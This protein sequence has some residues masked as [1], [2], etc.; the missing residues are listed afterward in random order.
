MTSNNSN[1]IRTYW[2]LRLWMNSRVLYLHESAPC[3]SFT[4][5]ST[6]WVVGMAKFTTGSVPSSLRFNVDRRPSSLANCWRHSSTVVSF[7]T[8]SLFSAT[9]TSFFCGFVVMNTTP[10]LHCLV[11]GLR[12]RRS[13]CR[14]CGCGCCCCCCWCCC[15]CSCDP[16]SPGNPP[17]P[18][19]L[20]SFV[21]NNDV[22]IG[23][24]TE[25]VEE[26]VI[27][28]SPSGI[29]V[30]MD[31]DVV[32][33]AGAVAAGFGVCWCGGGDGDGGVSSTI[34]QS[35][36]LCVCVCVF[37]CVCVCVWN[38]AWSCPSWTLQYHIWGIH[39]LWSTSRSHFLL[40]HGEKGGGRLF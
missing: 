35:V 22:N 6:S 23:D 13:R 31:A 4:C 8:G 39:W 17:C 11:R 33:A 10:S 7:T 37:V 25:R 15:C 24:G 36:V 14:R 30:G 20:S 40:L 28:S 16:P 26:N 18:F 9:I 38:D 32:A 12:S 19:L 3:S 34:L 27:T 21:G 1:P 5:R 2:T 29:V